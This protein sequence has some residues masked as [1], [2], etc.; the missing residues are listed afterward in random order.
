FPSFDWREREIAYRP[1]PYFELVN[2]DLVLKNQP[3]PRARRRREELAD[4]RSD[5]PYVPGDP[6]PYAI[7]KEA[8]SAPWRLM[9]KIL[10]RFLRQVKGKPVLLVPLPL[11]CHYL[12]QHPPT[13]GPRFQELADPKNRV[14]VV[15]VLPALTSLP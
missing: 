10:E 9:K 4:W 12:E 5:F 2:G 3:V 11:F 14:A 8:D 15:D 7:Y 6:D 13:W 1:K